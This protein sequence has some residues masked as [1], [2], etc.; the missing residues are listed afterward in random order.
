RMP[1]GN[2]YSYSQYT[3]S[4]PIQINPKLYMNSTW[5]K[6]IDRE[7]PTTTDELYEI[8]KAFKEEDPNGNGKTDEIPF[9]ASSLGLILNTFNG[10]WGLRNRRTD[11]GNVDM[12]EKTGELRFIPTDPNYKEMLEFI[13][14]LYT[15]G[16]IDEEIFTMD[17]AQLVAKG[18]Q[19]LVG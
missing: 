1:D 6:N 5:L 17:P 15:E 18:D 7:M 8:I 19:D 4:D 9:S 3:D 2:I 11:H 10:F 13:N 12:N 16:L 14:K